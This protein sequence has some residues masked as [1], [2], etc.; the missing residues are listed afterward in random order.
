M[1]KNG[2]FRRFLNIKGPFSQKKIAHG[3]GI[4]VVDWIVEKVFVVLNNF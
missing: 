3:T 1:T 2:Q 4:V